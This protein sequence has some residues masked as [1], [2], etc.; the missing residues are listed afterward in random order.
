[1]AYKVP[2]REEFLNIP[3]LAEKT[4]FDD[5]K[6]KMISMQQ[7]ISDNKIETTAYFEDT[8]LYVRQKLKNIYT[9]QEAEESYKDLRSK[10]SK[11][12]KTTREVADENKK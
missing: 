7:Q 4:I 6:R 5:I 8:Q 9:R 2:G 3:K 11:E 12:L 10:F 1:M